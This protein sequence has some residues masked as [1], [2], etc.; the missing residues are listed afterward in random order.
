MVFTS[1]RD[2]RGGGG[3]RAYRKRPSQRGHR[4]VRTS[5]GVN[6]RGQSQCRGGSSC[7]STLGKTVSKPVYSVSEAAHGVNRRRRAFIPGQD[8]LR[9]RSAGVKV[10][11]SEVLD[12]GIGGLKREEGRNATTALTTISPCELGKTGN[13]LAF[14]IIDLT[15]QAWGS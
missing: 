5:Q 8:D 6:R 1:K 12:I 13:K 10:R 9:V 2:Q 11:P 7:V 14:L 4:W 3:A 15:T